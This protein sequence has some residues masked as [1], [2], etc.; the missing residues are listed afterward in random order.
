VTSLRLQKLIATVSVILFAGKLGAY[1]FTRS[2]TVLADALESTVNVA[3]GF[4][5]LYSI[6]LAAKP[7]DTNHPYGHGK[8]EF[9]SAAIEGT[10][11]FISGIIILYEG[12]FQ[13]WQPHALAKLNVGLYV[14]A[15]TIVV[16]YSLGR[17]AIA[18]GRKNSSM[19]VQS[20]GNHLLADTYATLGVVMG[21]ALIWL[22]QHRFPWLD[23]AI[24]I[25]FS[26]LILVA[27]YRVLRRSISGIMDE[28]DEN[29]LK[30]VISVIQ[31]NRLPQWVDLHNLRVI[32][33]GNMM[34]MDAHMTLPWYYLVADADKEIHELE[35][36]IKDHFKEQVELFVH[37][38]GCMPYQCKLCAL[39]SCDVRQ[40]VYHRQ[41]VW[42]EANVFADAKHGKH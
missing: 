23:G 19:V 28:V 4:I 6:N 37:V 17:Y 29:L 25:I 14:L 1:W 35:L 7:R 26:L 40:E 12:V 36:L 33:Y 15:G 3:M 18:V 42:T 21:L 24:A 30:N 20:A 2:V 5:G 10:L 9:V 32:Q 13:L 31:R 41:L 38:D 16:N 8:A 11:I 39:S 34:H 27:G 22:T